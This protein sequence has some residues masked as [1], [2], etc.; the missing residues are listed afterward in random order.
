MTCFV[1]GFGDGQHIHFIDGDD[2]GYAIAAK[3]LK[4]RALAEPS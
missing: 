4:E 3:A 1:S 2:G